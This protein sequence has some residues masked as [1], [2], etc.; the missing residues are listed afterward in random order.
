[1]SWLEATAHNQI[2]FSRIGI[3]PIF[4]KLLHLTLN[5]F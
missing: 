3:L 4:E 5:Q 1:M 2:N